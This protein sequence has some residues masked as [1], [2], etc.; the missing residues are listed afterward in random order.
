M[1]CVIRRFHPVGQGGFMSER[2]DCFNIVYDCGS[3]SG[4]EKYRNGIKT[5]FDMETLE[6]N[7][8]I[9]FL[10]LSHFDYDH[11]NGLSILKDYFSIKSVIIPIINRYIKIF[12]KY[13]YLHDKQFI[14]F[15]DDTEN[16]FG[17]DTKFFWI[18]ENNE[19]DDHLFEFET[20]KIDTLTKENLNS[21]KGR[22]IQLPNLTPIKYSSDWVLVPYNINKSSLRLN[23]EL[24]LQKYKLDKYRILN[25]DVQYIETNLRT[26]K[27][28]Y[29]EID[30]DLNKN[31][32]ILYSG[33]DK[34]VSYP[35]TIFNN[36][37][38]KYGKEINLQK[39]KNFE[40]IK[41][42]GC[43][44]TGDFNLNSEDLNSI[45]KDYLDQIS[46]VQIPH[47]GSYASFNFKNLP[48]N[49]I[50]F[51][52]SYGVKNP[53]KHPS[54]MVIKELETKSRISLRIT[55]EIDTEFQQRIYYVGRNL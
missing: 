15:L 12:L 45:Y 37:I 51:P 6:G 11:I 23:I 50:F 14:K 27:I 40:E 20:Y 30:K 44:Y 28:I 3:T 43:I 42:V 29:K 24:L 36:F 9:D 16:Y 34:E 41:R 10:F 22:F 17:N 7:K 2:H 39:I 33:F 52:I 53:Y 8:N 55:N 18:N 48:K 26:L 13:I 38:Y 35:N 32:L 47:H 1:S 54:Q 5:S 25:E 19:N 21:I 31:S 49:A 4:I 46:T